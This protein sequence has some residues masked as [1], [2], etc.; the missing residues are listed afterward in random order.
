MR[1]S[2]LLALCFILLAT[3]PALTQDRECG[4]RETIRIFDGDANQVTCESA[5]TG[6]IEFRLSSFATPFVIVATDSDNIIQAITRNNKIDFSELGPGAYRVYGLFFKGNLLAEPGMSLDTSRLSDYCYGTTRNFVP[7]NTQEPEAGM[8]S[9]LNGLGTRFICPDDQ[10]D[11]IAFEQTEIV[12]SFTYAITDANNV[13]VAIPDSNS[14]DFNTLDQETSRVYGIAYIGNLSL[15]IG[16][17][18]SST[19]TLSDACFDISDNFLEVIQTSPDGGTVQRTNGDTTALLCPG[20]EAMLAIE[21]LDAAPTPF[22]LVLTDGDDVVIEVLESTTVDFGTQDP[23]TYRIYGISY[24]GNPSINAGDTLSSATLSDDCFDVS[25]NFVEVTIQFVDGGQVSLENGSRMTEV[26]VQDGEADELIFV[27]NS[28]ADD[29]SYIYILTNEDNEVILPLFGDRIDFDVDL[30]TGVNRVWG[31][32]YTGEF[33]LSTGQDIMATSLSDGCFNLSSTFVT[34]I[35]SR[36]I[37]GEIS[38]PDSSLTAQICPEGQAD[39][40]SFVTSGSSTGAYAYLATTTD[41]RIVEVSTDTF[42]AI[43]TIAADSLNIYGL[44]YSGELQATE[45]Q[46]ISDATLSDA[47]FTLSQNTVLVTAVRPNTG[48]IALDGGVTDTL[49][50]PEGMGMS[51]PISAPDASGGTNISILADTAGVIISI[52]EGLDF[53]VPADLEQGNYQ[54]WVATYTGALTLETGQSLAENPV[55]NDCFA[56]SMQGITIR[57]EAPMAGALTFQDGSESA[58]FCSQNGIADSLTWSVSES[59]GGL[60]TYLLTDT[61][62]QIIAVSERSAM[63]A[64]TLTPGTYRIH[65]LAYTGNLTALPGQDA[66][67]TALSDEC[68]QLGTNFLT[69]DAIEPI[70]GT[71]SLSEGGAV[72]CSGDGTPD[73]LKFAAT[74]ASPQADYIYLVTDTSD[75][76]LFDL[77]DSTSFDFETQLGGNMKVW[78][79]SY[80]GNLTI[81]AGDTVTSATLSDDCFSLSDNSVLVE[82]QEV[83]G[84]MIT[85]DDGRTTAYV[86]TGDGNPDEL[87]FVNDGESAG[88]QYLY[89]VT[90]DNDLVVATLS[91]NMQDFENTGFTELRVYGVSYAGNLTASINGNIRDIVFSDGCYE[92]SENFVTVVRDQPDASRISNLAG[93]TDVIFCPGPDGDTLRLFQTSTSAAGYIYLL[94]DT[95]STLLQIIEE[96]ALDMT[97]LDEGDYMLIGV[98]YTGQLLIDEGET[99]DP[100]TTEISNNCFVVSDNVMTLRKG[101]QV[102]GGLLMTSSGDLTFYTCPGDTLGD[103]VVVLAPSDTLAAEYRL[104]ITDENDRIEFP[105]VENPVI[106]FNRADPGIY[107]VYGVSFTGNFIPQFAQDL[108]GGDISSECYEPSGN[109]IEIFNFTPNSSLVSTADGLTEVAA[110]GNASIDFS[111]QGA[112]PLLPYRFLLTDTDNSVIQV[113][114]DSTLVTD[115]LAEGSYRIWGLNYTGNLLAEAGSQADA[116]MLADNCFIL[117]DNFVSLTVGSPVPGAVQTPVATNRYLR[118]SPN[119]ATDNLQLQFA[120]E[121]QDLSKDVRLQVI[122]LTGSIVVDR[123]VG[124]VLGNNRLDI[125]IGNLEQGMYLVRL[126]N[127]QT[128]HQGRF[129]KTQP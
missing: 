120:L 123:E 111:Q 41:G 22:T 116:D 65:A 19:A 26:C 66:A 92:L 38:L 113:M 68:F 40:L 3:T 79:L 4:G 57:W 44:A 61:T 5:A 39:T 77:G 37:G 101:G 102:D 67:T 69:L 63:D 28:T 100:A 43:G 32:S 121:Q 11:I 64:D 127:G 12:G 47:C 110:D 45:G 76:F 10:A 95:D 112:T 115:T 126:T 105:D 82:R 122:D 70:G 118:L 8:I 21:S 6:V 98:S 125:T 80:T 90:T 103:A 94:M 96:D 93:E 42:L 84:G 56:L 91:G 107:R 97:P 18:I 62:N 81:E 108:F 33:N 74:G 34:I 87:T 129:L 50:C 7:I 78:G 15:N 31:L 29:A 2:C 25:N 72:F 75:A 16:D 9:D 104:I 13:V 89:V 14:F 20:E 49:L 73:I 23:G 51:L 55:S 88:S 46:F 86:C 1:P 71:I 35:K 117:S 58:V 36:V 52:Q 24:T 60:L 54:L 114:E 119:P 83:D 59:A 106:D 17:T 109:F 53:M 99:I 48:A 124:V 27:N 85:T 30:I 128:I